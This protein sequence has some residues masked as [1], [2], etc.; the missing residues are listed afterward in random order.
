MPDTALKLPAEISAGLDFRVDFVLPGYEGWEVRLVMRGS[1]SIDL[2]ADDT[3]SQFTFS[4]AASVTAGWAEGDYWYSIRASL[5]AAVRELG[6]GQTKVLPDLAAIAGPYDGRSQDEIA[7]AALD[8][9]LAKKATRDQQ[10]YTINNRELWRMSVA[11][12]LKLRAFYVVKVR[13]ARRGAGFG[14]A[15]VVQFSDK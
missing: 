13:R 9:V 3:G 6:R 11:E 12:L 5:G 14:R 4:A 1:E 7:L 15:V 8:A 2:V 10:R